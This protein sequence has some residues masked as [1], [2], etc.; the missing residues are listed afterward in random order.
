MKCYYYAFF[1]VESLVTYSVYYGAFRSVIQYSA[2]RCM[3]NRKFG[4]AFWKK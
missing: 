2:S 4:N 1:P 3:P